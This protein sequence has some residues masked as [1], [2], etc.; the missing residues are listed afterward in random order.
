MVMA[1]IIILCLGL[2]TFLLDLGKKLFM[3]EYKIDEMMEKIHNIG[4]KT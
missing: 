3:K 4:K 1:F 2:G